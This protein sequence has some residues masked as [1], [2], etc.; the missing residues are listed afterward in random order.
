MYRRQ[1]PTVTNTQTTTTAGSTQAVSSSTET[2]DPNLVKAGPATGTLGTATYRALVNAD[3][4]VVDL[5][6]GGT[7]VSAASLSALRTYLGLAIGTNVP[8]VDGTGATGTWP[9]SVTGNAATAT[10]AAG[11]DTGG[12]AT[13]AYDSGGGAWVF[14]GGTDFEVQANRFFG[15]LTGNVTGNAT[16]A[17]TASKLGTLTG[18][19]VC[20]SGTPSAVT[21]PSGILKGANSTATPT[22]AS[23]ADVATTLG[24]Q[25]A[26]TVYSGPASGSAAAPGFRALAVDDI[27][28]QPNDLEDMADRSILGWSGPAMSMMT[29][30]NLPTGNLWAVKIYVRKTCSVTGLY[31][32]QGNAQ[33]VSATGGADNGVALYD[34]TGLLIGKSADQAAT[35]AGSKNALR[36]VALTGG[37]FTVTGGPGVYVYA[38]ILTN[39]GTTPNFYRH[40]FGAAAQTNAGLTSSASACNLQCGARTGVTNWPTGAHG[41]FTL[42]SGLYPPW[43]ALY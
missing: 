2:A 24:T 4:P 3:L 22:A 1:Q 9:I 41:L 42:S 37:P 31:F 23:G 15:P 40:A 34:S 32:Y 33:L 19:P 6:H 20:S 7:G 5:A 28:Y 36:Q 13:L 10:T 8:G 43:M 17:T 29:D 12:G 25:T 38:C 18:I 21:W 30:T 14:S 26:N 39:A 11:L 16:T 35:W 27:P